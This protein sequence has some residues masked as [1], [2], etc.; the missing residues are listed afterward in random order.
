MVPST[1]H[2]S[3]YPGLFLFTTPAR[4]M[5]PVRNLSSNTVEY[6]GTFEQVY[7][8][9]SVTPKEIYPKVNVRFNISKV[10]KAMTINGSNFFLRTLE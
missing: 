4:M 9:I 5:R 3:Q 6:I 8:N 7:L 1:E 2:K 10:T